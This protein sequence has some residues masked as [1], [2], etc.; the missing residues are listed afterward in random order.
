MTFCFEFINTYINN[1][2]TKIPMI[3]M[4]LKLHHIKHI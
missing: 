4:A 1:D 2:L 3:N